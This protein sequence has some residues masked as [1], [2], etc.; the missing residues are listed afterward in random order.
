MAVRSARSALA[1]S[2]SAPR[3]HRCRIAPLSPARRHGEPHRPKVRGQCGRSRDP[4][5]VFALAG[6]SRSVE[7]S[8]GSRRV[9]SPGASAPRR[10][11]SQ[12]T[13][14]RG[15]T[16]R[17]TCCWGSSRRSASTPPPRSGNSCTV[18]P[19]SGVY[20]ARLAS[21]CHRPD[22]SRGPRPPWRGLLRGANSRVPGRRAKLVAYCGRPGHEIEAPRLIPAARQ[23]GEEAH[24]GRDGPAD[25]G[26]R[27]TEAAPLGERQ[28]LTPR[29]CGARDRAS[30]LGPQPPAAVPPVQPP[31]ARSGPRRT[32][33]RES[34][35][36]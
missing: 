13:S 30:L 25:A 5:C 15:A 6:G 28:R 16:S 1:L 3:P 2:W 17:C 35:P 14:W 20:A 23:A 34:A 11:R 36:P 10:H 21:G 7:P 33:D 8:M 22:P 32:P 26:D 29:R 27:V 4:R 24:E 12:I 18:S 9:S 31:P 19:P